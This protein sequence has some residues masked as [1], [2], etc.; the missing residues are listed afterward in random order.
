MMF[1]NSFMEYKKYKKELLDAI[2]N[3]PINTDDIQASKD[4]KISRTDYF[5]PDA[6]RPYFKIFKKII[7]PVMKEMC[8]KLNSSHYD[9]LYLW[10]QQY[11][12]GDVH[13]WHNHTGSQFANVFFVELEDNSIGTEFLDP[14]HNTTVKEGDLITFPAYLYHR[15]PVNLTNTRKTVISFNSSFSLFRINESQNNK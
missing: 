5:I 15:S 12:H 2:N 1:K 4:D 11:N 7:D 13:D 14:K 9:I 10:F 6:E 8:K 3:M